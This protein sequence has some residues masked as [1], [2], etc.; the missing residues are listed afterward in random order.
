MLIVLN[1]KMNLK[2]E[3]ITS[4]EKTLRDYNVVVMPQTPY[5]GLFTKGKYTLGSQCIS[6][7]NAPGGVSADALVGLNV[8]YVIVG[9]AERRLIRNECDDVIA[10]KINTIINNEMVPILCVGES[11]LE[12]QAGL[13]YRVIERQISEVFTKVNKDYHKILIAYEPVWSIGTSNPPTKEEIEEV[14]LFIK[15]YLKETYVVE[16]DLLYGGSVSS[17]N[18]KELTEIENIKGV[19]VGS[20]SLDIQEVINIYNIVN[21]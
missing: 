17:D 5:M 15:N 12:K 2:I 9:H 13:T 1:H 8:K 18:M 14:L 20:A 3:E 10:K 7:Y 19:I 11:L 16:T 6:E 4:Y 21:N